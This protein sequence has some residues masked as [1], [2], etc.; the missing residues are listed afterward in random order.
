MQLVIDGIEKNVP[1]GAP[2]FC[3]EYN[4]MINFWTLRP[5]PTRYNI[6]ISPILHTRAQVEEVL[7]DLDRQPDSYV[8]LFVPFLAGDLFGAR[9]SQTYQVV[10]RFPWAVLLQKKQ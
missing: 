6:F 5:N 2:V 8:L 10:W 7:E 1:P 9:V 4:A 3:T